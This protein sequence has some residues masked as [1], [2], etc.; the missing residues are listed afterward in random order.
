MAVF[1]CLH[2]PLLAQAPLQVAHEHPHLSRQYKAASQA[3][4]V[5]ATDDTASYDDLDETADDI[6]QAH[7]ISEVSC[8]ALPSELP[9]SFA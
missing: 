8:C 6:E 7:G 1:S 9:R 3:Q 4:V 5:G 2:A